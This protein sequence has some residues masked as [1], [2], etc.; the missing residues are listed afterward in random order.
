MYLTNAGH[1]SSS[2][3]LFF[4]FFKQMNTPNN[5]IKNISGEGRDLERHLFKFLSRVRC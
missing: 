5:K 3:L 2:A 4:F 1:M